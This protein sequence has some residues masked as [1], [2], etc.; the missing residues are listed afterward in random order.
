MQSLRLL[1]LKDA[2]VVV[3][4]YALQCI[5]ALARGLRRGLYVH[6]SSLITDVLLE[7]LK[8]KKLSTH[9]RD[10]LDACLA[11]SFYAA[12]SDGNAKVSAPH[13]SMCGL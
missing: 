11:C 13:C 1:A 4:Q 6:A 9:L 8:E 2:N 10:A 3:V 12:H 7:K 5:I